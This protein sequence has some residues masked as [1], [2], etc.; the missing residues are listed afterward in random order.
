MPADICVIGVPSIFEPL[1]R[2]EA[3]VAPG[4]S[5]AEIV[6]GVMPGAMADE[7]ACVEVSLSGTRIAPGL[8]HLTHPKAG[9]VIVIAAGPADDGLRTF[10]QVAI[11]VAAIA[12]GQFYGATLATNL[13]FAAT[14]ALAANIATAAI[15][16]TVL[17][18]GNALLD[19][20]V[21]AT[22]DDKNKPTYAINGLRNNLTPNGAIPLVL[23]KVRY[24]PPFAIKPWTRA[25][26]DERF[27]TTAFCG[28]IGPL[29]YSEMRIGKTPIERFPNITTEAQQGYAT[30]ARLALSPETVIEEAPQVELLTS[31]VTF[32]GPV[33]RATAADVSRYEVDIT[34]PG[35]LFATNSDGE[36]EAWTVDITHEYRLSGTTPWLSAGTISVTSDKRKAITRTIPFTP[37]ARGRY[38]VRLTRTTTDWDE[39]DQS[40]KDIKRSGRSFWAVLR[41]IRPEY[42]I[43][44]PLPCCLFGLRAQGSAQVN[45]QLD[46]FNV[47]LSSICP[48]WDAPTQTWITR[49]TNNPASLFRYVL[50][51]PAIAYPLTTAQ[52]TALGDWHAFCVSKGLKY[53]RVHD[54]PSASVY[55]V[56]R[57]I[58]AVGRA[59]PRNGGTTW[60]VVID[61]AL[62]YVSAHVSPRNSW[63]F[64]GSRSYVKKPDAFRVPF[65]DETNDYEPA[66]RVVPWPTFTGTPKIVE[67]FELPG[68]TDPALVWK[69]ARRRQYE[70]E[71]R[72]DTFTVN[73]DFEALGTER[74]DRVQLNQ[75]V[76]DTWQKAARTVSV[77]DRVLVLD[78]TVTMQAGQTYGFYFQQTGGTT[79]LHT[80][81]T[82]AGDTRTLIVTSTGPMP[83]AGTSGADGDL[84]HFGTSTGTSLSCTVKDVETMDNFT[85]R[86]TLIP[87]APN[88]ETLVDAEVPPAWSGRAGATAQAPTGTPLTP[89]VVSVVSGRLAAAAATTANPYPVLVNLRPDPANLIPL[90]TYQVQHR[91]SGSG[92]WLGPVSAPVAAGSVMLS[93]YAKTN[94]VEVQARAVSDLGTP[95]AWTATVTHTV[96]ATDPAA[97]DVPVYTSNTLSGTTVTHTFTFPAD[98]TAEG[99]S[100]VTSIKLYRAKGWDKTF[101][102][103]A[104]RKTIAGGQNQTLS[105]TDQ[106]DIGYYKYWIVAVNR[107]GIASAAVAGADIVNVTAPG[108]II[109]APFDL[110]NAAYSRVRLDPPTSA[111]ALVEGA[112]SW[113]VPETTGTTALTHFFEQ[114]VTASVNVPNRLAVVVKANGRNRMQL[115]LLN[116]ANSANSNVSVNLLTG[117][118]GV[119]VSGTGFSSATAQMTKMASD[120]YLVEMTTTPTVAALRWRLAYLD[121]SGTSIYL[122][123]NTKK[124]TLTAITLTGAVPAAAKGADEV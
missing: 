93:G 67:Q 81:Q 61:K 119:P 56:L 78:D 11:V 114:N 97:P 26:G 72:P 29:A 91:L 71:N 43:N 51:G 122:G 55:D 57:S 35:G 80:V 108:N 112:A 31:V 95:S 103:A 2:V 18:A 27:L 23:G 121:D 123:D 20:L 7:T 28:G 85:A 10:L 118:V 1:R 19:A 87:H 22:K 69:E 36:F 59:S 48:D 115:L 86:L 100:P 38:E 3:H 54:D 30:D 47:I 73:Q 46:G 120:V 124:L 102:Q 13:G 44:P 75:D 88:I 77:T 76:L 40:K 5:L 17:Y 110:T 45:G 34:F 52:V 89:I 14:N 79:V 116:P 21:P 82:R 70:I 8:W 107:S 4:P 32:G 37:P 6:E 60:G 53:N 94:V 68:I 39:A 74:G 12:S 50:T 42:P 33:I 104:L 9:A 62:D 84:I 90:A 83:S 111:V 16:S 58:A 105:T 106:I 109:T 99:T 96:A 41:S 24:F 63:G 92:T 25:V 66:E 98:S 113:D 101:A 15:T 117:T 65:L 64:E 49:E